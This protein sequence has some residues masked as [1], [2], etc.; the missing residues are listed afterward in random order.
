M[1]DHQSDDIFQKAVSLV[2]NIRSKQLD[3][4]ALGLSGLKNLP[5]LDDLPFV[6]QASIK[7]LRGPLDELAK[8]TN[9]RR[10]SIS[11]VGQVNLEPIGRLDRLEVL[12]ISD[13]R[14]SS[15]EPLRNLTRLEALDL[16]YTNV[17]DLR[18]IARLRNL[19]SLNLRGSRVSD[20]TPISNL[21]KLESLNISR[22]RVTS[23]RPI[24]KL[25]SLAKGAKQTG[26]QYDQHT[27]GGILYTGA[28][29]D[30]PLFARL[31]G[32]R[33]KDRTEAVLRH[34]RTS[35]DNED[36]VDTEWDDIT[37]SNLSA[38]PTPFEFSF[39]PGKPIEVTGSS[40][41]WP[42][43]PLEG[44][45]SDLANRLAASREIAGGIVE[46][47][48]AGEYQVRREYVREFKRYLEKLPAEPGTGNILLADAAARTLRNLFDA[49]AQIL[50][51]GFA[52]SLKTFLEQ[53]IGL[54]AYYPEIQTFYADVR[55]GKLNVPL[56]LD[57]TNKFARTVREYTPA[58]FAPSVSTALTETS[59]SDEPVASIP[60][61]AVS[62]HA[63]KFPLPPPDPLGQ[64]EPAKARNLSVAA[65]IGKLW[66]VFLAGQEINKSITD[67][68]DAGHKLKP[69]VQLIVEWYKKYIEGS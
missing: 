29:L 66:R 13:S 15:I 27:F 1:A 26:Y 42:A 19:R 4:L 25:D 31:A 61:A 10:L 65:T 59:S 44:S 14:F 20:L 7:F 11:F 32:Q 24:A 46:G 52:S 69:Y 23:L 48:E 30:D 58:V 9:L 22:T 60:E 6:T 17:V 2:A 28:P 21:T 55:D 64:L 63:D 62:V 53:H 12:V 36:A 37:L 39:H 38:V 47:L 54:R 3:S 67:W 49:D 68:I 16:S 33:K 50:S 35:K 34:L 43:L 41:N 40:A 51:A 57:A 18:P 8:L 56:P 5:P 45:A